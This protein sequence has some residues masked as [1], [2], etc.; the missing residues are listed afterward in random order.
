MTRKIYFIIALV[1]FCLGIKAQEVN[2][3]ILNSD[4]S[5][6]ISVSF[7]GAEEVYIKGDLLPKRQTLRTP[8]GTFGERKKAEME[9][10]LNGIWTYTTK[11]LPSELYTYSFVVDDKD[12]FDIANPNRFYD[13][14]HVLN[15]FLVPDG[16]ANDYMV[17]DVPHGKVS[18]EWYKSSL[19]NLPQRR[20]TVYTPAGYTTSKKYPVLYLLHGTGGDETSW[21]G[22][23]RAQQILDNLIAAKRC[24]PMIVVMPNGIVNRAAAPGADPY[25]KTENS[26]VSVESMMGLIEYRF[27]PEVVRYVENNY[28]VYKDKSYRAIAGLSLGGLHTL[29]ITANNPDEFDYVG[30]FSAQTT[31]SVSSGKKIEGLEKLA[32]NIKKLPEAFPFLGKGKKVDQYA[33]YVNEDKLTIYDS[34]DVKLQRQFANPPK[35]YYIAYGNDDFVKK[36]NEDFRNKLGAA[37]YRYTLNITDGG[38][39][40]SNWRK[41]LVDFLPRLFH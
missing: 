2:P 8:V 22:L 27:I 23:G 1:G 3:V 29:F 6:T 9:R 4:Q 19:P 37:G 26:G 31:N 41:Y 16:I 24:V 32:D 17:K 5:A 18:Y 12:T 30:L 34:L 36:L 21:I 10:G 33:D 28:S 39:T 14:G 20:M 35:L 38:H 25:N 15:A 13:S 7:P 11:F 40:W